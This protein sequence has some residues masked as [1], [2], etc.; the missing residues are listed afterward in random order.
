M[1]FAPR[2]GLL[3]NHRHPPHG[4]PTVSEAIA[5]ELNG[6]DLND[7][8][9]DKRAVT[10]LETLAANPEASINAACHGWSETQ[11]AYR[12]FDNEAV[13]PAALL[14]P[15]RAATITRVKQRPVALIVQDTT[16]L[17]YGGHPPGDARCLNAAHRRGLYAHCHLAVTPDKLNLGVLRVDYHDRDPDSLGKTEER[18]RWPIEEKESFRWLDGYRLAC[19]VAAAAPETQVVSVA[20]READIYDIFVDARRNEGPKAEFIIRSRV[21]RNTTER[22]RAKGPKTYGKVRDDVASSPVLATRVIELPATPKRAARQARLEIRAVSVLVRPPRD[23][24]RRPEVMMNV[25]LVQEVGGPGDGTDV[26]WLLLTSLPV[27]TGEQI[28]LAVDYYV[29]RW[30]VELFFKTWKSGCRVE[31][32]QLETLARLKNCLAVYAIVAWRIM[33]VT[34]EARIDPEQPCTK[35]FA[36]IEWQAVWM[37]VKKQPL[38]EEPPTLG[39]LLK[40][41]AILGGHNNRVGEPPPGPQTIWTGMRRMTDF[42]RAWQIFARV[43]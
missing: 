15:H 32:I 5:D 31:Q 37:V 6:I 19:D 40:M 11:A 30:A 23:R 42:A 26:E 27:G 8:R 28:L 3:T 4:A 41:L 14:Q 24:L 22:D 34:Y 35:A 36:D 25:V 39:E 9:L 12:F 43:T 16:E 13:T 2:I 10:I 17:D 20:D 1:R 21:E 33:A 29:A 7:K 18:E 38:P